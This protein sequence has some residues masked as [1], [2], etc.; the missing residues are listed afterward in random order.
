MRKNRGNYRTIGEIT[1]AM[2]K[3]QDHRRNYRS[4]GEITGAGKIT[5]P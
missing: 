5:G 4:S 3:L 2:G 1:G